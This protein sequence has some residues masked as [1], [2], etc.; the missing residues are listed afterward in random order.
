MNPRSIRAWRSLVVVGED[1]TIV[2]SLATMRTTTTWSTI[3][4][5]AIDLTCKIWPVK[6]VDFLQK[7]WFK[8]NCWPGLFLISRYLVQLIRSIQKVSTRLNDSNKGNQNEW[9][10]LQHSTN[11]SYPRRQVKI[12]SIGCPIKHFSKVAGFKRHDTQNHHADRKN[13]KWYFE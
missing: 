12:S 10:E 3:R 9:Q 1:D 4:A 2:S 8:P 5:L 7:K 13:L 11:F 6:Q